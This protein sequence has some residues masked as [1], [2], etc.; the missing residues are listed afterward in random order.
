MTA[1]LSVCSFLAGLL[2]GSFLNVCIYRIPRDLSVVAPRSF[3][4]ECGRQLRWTEN[5]PLLSFL[6]LRG[7]CRSCLQPIPLHY[8]LVELLCGLAFF[9]CFTRYG[10]SLVSLKWIV[11]EMLL[12]GLFWTDLEERILPDE[13]TLG[14]SLLGLLFAF[15]IPV[16]GT[17]GELLVPS[18]GWL[19][20]SVLNA[21]LGAFLLSVPIWL[22]ATL[23]GR[24]RKREA[25]GFG[26]VK[27]LVMLGLFLGP[28][29]GLLAL[30]AASVAGAVL[31]IALLVWK[32]KEAVTYEL[33]LGSFLCAA[34]C[35]IP[36]FSIH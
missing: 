26:D 32:R 4:P 34:A 36:F 15:F 33:P 14:G 13:L 12:I 27:L 5:I 11:F 17:L 20:F 18:L 31:G 2:F 10:L 30:L 1:Y 29:K 6:V 21:L 19:G 3:C 8:P 22:I 16:P 35:S 9:F 7:R 24:L 23:W 28:D 25:L